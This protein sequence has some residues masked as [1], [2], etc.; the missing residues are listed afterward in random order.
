MRSVRG[1]ECVRQTASIN[2]ASRAVAETPSMFVSLDVHTCSHVARKRPLWKYPTARQR[3]THAQIDVDAPTALAPSWHPERGAALALPRKA[4]LGDVALVDRLRWGR[5]PP[6]TV[7]AAAHSA[8]A[9]HA[10]FSPSGAW[11]PPAANEGAFTG[12]WASLCVHVATHTSA[13]TAARC[14][15]GTSRCSA[16]SAL[17]SESFAQQVS[18]LQT[19][20]TQEHAS[21]MKRVRP[22]HWPQGSQQS[23]RFWLSLH[24][25][26]SPPSTIARAADIDVAW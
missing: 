16:A 13:G 11:L 15:A 17:M 21:E 4:P 23:A 18:V 26:P 2:P 24:E 7:G 14:T 9:T 10:L 6:R 19:L 1:R 8:A 3:P 5:T 20:Q 22:W 25:P 12:A